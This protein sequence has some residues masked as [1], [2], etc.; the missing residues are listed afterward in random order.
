MMVIGEVRNAEK[1]TIVSLFMWFG[2]FG[3][4]L[5]DQCTRG[6]FIIIRPLFGVNTDENL[7]GTSISCARSTNR[8]PNKINRLL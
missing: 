1:L 3:T 4:V 8:W 6:L 2:P 5:Y 7:I